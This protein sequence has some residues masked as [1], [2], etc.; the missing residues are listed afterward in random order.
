MTRTGEKT[1]KIRVNEAKLLGVGSI[2]RPIGVKV[3]VARGL[4]STRY[5]HSYS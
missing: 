2:D 5:L 4:L 3:G 1:R